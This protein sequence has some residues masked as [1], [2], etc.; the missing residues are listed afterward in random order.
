M[1]SAMSILYF[2]FNSWTSSIA[3]RNIA[4]IVVAEEIAARR[5]EVVRLA[6]RAAAAKIISGISSAVT[7]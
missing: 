1:L 4:M 6:R 5:F 7:L 3:I 2:E